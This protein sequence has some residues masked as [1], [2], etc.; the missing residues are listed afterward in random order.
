MDG[1][2]RLWVPD[3]FRFRVTALDSAGNELARIGSYGNVDSAGPGSLVPQPPIPFTFPNAVA[4][5]E[6]RLYVADR[7]SGRIVV[8]KIV[9]ATEETCEVR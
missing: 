8:A 1:Y 6:D 2:G 9:Y 5:T 7:K 3:V 4:V